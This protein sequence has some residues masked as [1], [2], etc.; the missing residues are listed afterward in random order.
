MDRN[1]II[2]VVLIGVILIGYSIF[3]QPSTE[4]IAAKRATADSLNIVRQEAAKQLKLD[5]IA[6]VNKQ[7]AIDTTIVD[8]LAVDAVTNDSINNIVSNNKYGV[9]AD[10]SKGN[11]EYYTIENELLKLKISSKA[12]RIV[13]AIVKNYQTYDSL[14][15]NLLREKSSKF[16]LSFFAGNL[17][18][19][20][21]DLYFKAFKEENN[22]LVLR[23]YADNDDKYIEY[24]YDLSKNNYFVDFNIN[25]NGLN[26]IIPENRDFIT[27][28]W[29]QD[30]P[31]QELGG[32]N[33]NTYS[34]IYYKPL[35]E[36]PDYLSETSDEKEDISVGIRWISFKDQFFS[37][38]LICKNDG[39]IDASLETKILYEENPDFIKNVK[40][41]ISIPFK[42][43]KEE[44]NSFYFYLGPNKYSTLADYSDTEFT[45][46]EEE[47]NLQKLIP[48]GWGIFSWVNRFAI[49]PIFNFLN[50][51]ISNYGLII[52]LLTI[53][54]KLVLFPLTY[55][56]YLSTA[57]MRVLKPQIDEINKKIPK[58]KPMDRQ[59]AT[60]ALY[61]KVGVSPMGGCLP[62][63]LQFPIL[64]AMFRFFPASIELRQQSF[65]WAHDLS[66]YDSI[67]DL[68]FTIPIYG[69]HISLFTILMTISTLLYTKMQNE[70]NTANATMPG[71][72]TMMY[73]MPVM[74]MVMLN[75]YSSGLT[76]YYFL[77]NMITFSQMYFIKSRI[78]DED[79]LRKL[80][81]SKKKAP[82]K[83]SKF[84]QRLEEMAKKR[85]K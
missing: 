45:G 46:I 65:L 7:F 13:E 31:K 63:L 20:T 42:G 60:M 52:F 50:S 78:N 41:N 22:K 51:F 14:P 59:Q 73:I 10:A 19:Q 82:K 26:E 66:T 27:L 48:L 9:F 81:T 49:I 38:T 44:K 83:Q 39:F 56:S 25:F 80:E 4:E 43:K 57:K 85:G 54:I 68:P 30:I 15:L 8:T 35:L 21:E 71:M 55:K 16:N 32:K 6:E 72:K 53:I 67:V 37:S 74:F 84:Q 34:T 70:M 58:D 64:L 76:Y 12:G 33:E 79:I 2:G 69:A 47:L 3:T 77:A 23:A 11:D 36:D 5:S 40:A 24:S 28:N 62:M 75:N 1:S 29:E 61:K 18:I 17:V